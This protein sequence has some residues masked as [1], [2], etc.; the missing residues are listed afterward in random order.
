MTGEDTASFVVADNDELARLW[1]GMPRKLLPYWSAMHW[2]PP[3]SVSGAKEWF[4]KNTTDSTMLIR[5]PDVAGF[6]VLNP[7][8]GEHVSCWRIL[9]G[10]VDERDWIDHCAGVLSQLTSIV[11]DDLNGEKCEWWLPANWQTQRAAAEALGYQL[12]ASYP[13]ACWMAG[14]YHDLQLWG[15]L[16]EERTEDGE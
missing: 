15:L 1:V 14:R 11:L 3:L 10:F 13:D 4:D 16:K 2:S 8:D 5:T 6:A 12:E 9:I 7:D